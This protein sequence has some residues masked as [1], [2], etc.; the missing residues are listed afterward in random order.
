MQLH[1]ES[2][3]YTKNTPLSHRKSLGQYMTPGFIG[4]LLF[5][6]LPIVSGSKILDP[7]VGTGEL[8]LAAGRKH[9]IEELELY[10]WEIDANI[11][12]I[13]QKVVPSAS[14][15][16]QSLFA[17]ID[18]KWIG[19]FDFVIGNPPY[20]ELKK[21]DFNSKD[22]IVSSGRTNIYS[23]FFEKYLPLVKEDGYLAYII[24]PSMNAG[25][26]FSELRKYV[27]QNSQILNLEIVRH[28]SHFV[29]AL[30]SVQIIVLQKKSSPDIKQ[31]STNNFIVD[32]KKLT[33]NPSAPFIFTDNK[34][35]IIKHWHDKKSL[36][37]YGYEAVTGT[38][39]WNQYKDKLSDKQTQ[40]SGKL[41]YAKDIAP[42]NTI[43][44]SSKLDS[45]RW[46]ST[47]KPAINGSA[48]LINRIVGS[49]DAPR[50]KIAKVIDN[51]YYA[52]NH[53]NVIRPIASKTQLISLDEIYNRLINYKDL[54]SY[55]QAITGNTQ[56]SAK[57]LT[58]LLPL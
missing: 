32:F 48:I 37:D 41:Y 36:F 51:N 4:D 30:T 50:L 17:S 33:N 22:F 21:K 14:M 35:I 18:A 34:K 28:N 7:A 19:Y 45:R 49:L 31:I 38:I 9:E 26:Y 11:L 3:E 58:Y 42:T 15:S 13:G 54:S 10:G 24:P 40:G 5:K 57:E 2:I 23:L 12:K 47:S 6:T 8:L 27:V 44:F 43:K 39:P 56:L 46:L 25:A 53:I 52:E 55:L 29:D 16:I 20:F 1:H